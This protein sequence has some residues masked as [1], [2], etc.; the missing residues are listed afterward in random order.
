V[1]HTA[2]DLASPLA[3]GAYRVEAQ[4]VDSDLQVRFDTQRIAYYVDG[5]MRTNPHPLGE[6]VNG[7][8]YCKN[9]TT[10]KYVTNGILRMDHRDI[11]FT[12]ALVADGDVIEVGYYANNEL[13]NKFVMADGDPMHRAIVDGLVQ[14]LKRMDRVDFGN[15]SFPY[16]DGEYE[17]T[18]GLWISAV[19]AD[20]IYVG[21]DL[22]IGWQ[23]LLHFDVEQWNSRHF[24]DDWW[25]SSRTTYNETPFYLTGISIVMD[26]DAVSAIATHTYDRITLRI[27]INGSPAKQGGSSEVHYIPLSNANEYEKIPTPSGTSESIIDDGPGHLFYIPLG[28]VR[29]YS[30]K[31][32]AKVEGV[33]AFTELSNRGIWIDGWL[34]DDGV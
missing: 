21:S 13:A 14:G 10:G 26:A 15:N 20:V 8:E 19:W 16:G 24:N 17:W 18:F 12:P 9:L 11:Q 28:I 34:P 1:D 27:T 25:G 6:F 23:T 29:A 31:I 30:I 32:D 33:E 4:V 22:G 3:L 5:V 2:Q 7:V